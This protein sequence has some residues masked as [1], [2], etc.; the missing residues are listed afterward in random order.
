MTKS[1]KFITEYKLQKNTYLKVLPSILFLGAGLYILFSYELDSV[2]LVLI[3]VLLILGITPILLLAKIIQ[4]Y[5]DLSLRVDTENQLFE[6]RNK[7]ENFNIPF[8]DI[9]KIETFNLPFSHLLFDYQNIK[10]TF[11]DDKHLY[12]N[13]LMTD[14]FYI[15]KNVVEKVNQQMFPKIF[16][17]ICKL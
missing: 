1:T 16:E 6:V 15:P 11:N 5:K 17:P 8:K 2:R 7:K 14:E 3:S 12:V 13:N 4:S 10:Y 9:T